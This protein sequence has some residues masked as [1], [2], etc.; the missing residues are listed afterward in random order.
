M[1]YFKNKNSLATGDDLYVIFE[2]FLLDFEIKKSK[3]PKINT[4]PK[5]DKE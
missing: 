1:I 2:S 5:I 3:N 4:N